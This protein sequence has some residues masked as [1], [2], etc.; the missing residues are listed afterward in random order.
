METILNVSLI[1][2]R[3]KKKVKRK[4]DEDEAEDDA[5]V[6]KKSRQIFLPLSM[7]MMVARI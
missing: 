5:E 1:F 7:H 3:W 6:K 4:N 2:V